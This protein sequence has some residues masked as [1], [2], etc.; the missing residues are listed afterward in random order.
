M[1]ATTGNALASTAGIPD[2][3]WQPNFVTLETT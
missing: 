1:L 2:K 3:S